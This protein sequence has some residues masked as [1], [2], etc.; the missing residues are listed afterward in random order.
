MSDKFTYSYSAKEQQE[1]EQI[2]QKYIPKTESALDQMKKLDHQVNQ[3]ATMFAI[4]FGIVSALVLGLGMCLTMV[5]AEQFFYL[6]IVIG[7]VGIICVSLTL[8]LYRRVLAKERHK[9][10]DTIIQLSQEYSK[11]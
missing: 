7:V 3:K 1:I 8:P 2:R 4:A 5:W 11:Q 10:A 9:V 6:G